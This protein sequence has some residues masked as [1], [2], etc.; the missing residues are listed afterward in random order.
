MIRLRE[1]FFNG[2]T[3]TLNVILYKIIIGFLQIEILSRKI[4]AY[5]PK[6]FTKNLLV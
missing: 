2:E 1:F 3:L 6:N 5:T 4:H